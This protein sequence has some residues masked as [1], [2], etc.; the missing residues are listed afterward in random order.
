M[1]RTLP[2]DARAG[3]P[4]RA[5]SLSLALAIFLVPS[6][7]LAQAQAAVRLELA[8]PA[9]PPLVVIQPGVQ[10][11]AD[12]DD[13]VFFVERSYWLRRDGRWYRSRAPRAA[14]VS[15]DTRRVPRALVT[16]APGQY[17][18]YRAASGPGEPYPSQPPPPPRMRPPPA[19]PPPHADVL[20]VK[21]IKAGRVRARA[22]FAKEVKANGGRIGR[23]FEDRDDER[24]EQGRADGEI[25]AP[26]VRADVIYAKKV[27]ADW[28]EA[29]E[30]HAKKVE[31]GR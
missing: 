9:V 29:G 10:V 21:E 3:R 17:R 2:S 5:F 30:I 13:E 6:V 22:I 7:P 1:T 14:F 18:H 26:D 31:I 20:R 12:L 16:L 23:I 25:K 19:P 24:W 15:V 4:L 28:I 11:V 8:L 27:E